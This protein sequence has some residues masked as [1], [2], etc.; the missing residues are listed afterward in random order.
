MNKQDG[1]PLERKR[2]IQEGKQMKRRFDRI[3]C[4]ALLCTMT[5]SLTACGN[6]IPDLTEDQSQQIGEYAAV[7]LL[8]YDAN[9]RSRLVE[10]DVVIARM[11]KE[12]QKAEA[13]E[14]EQTQEPSA[15][16][17]EMT[18]PAAQEDITTSL[19][20][21]FGLA[22]GLNLSYENAQIL[23]SYPEDGAA[24][25]YFAL[26]ASEG[27]KLLV[28]QFRLENTTAEAADVDLLGTASRYVITVNNTYR[29][30]ALTTMLPNDL[31]AYAGTIGAGEGEE[32]VLLAEIDADMADAVESIS[33]HLKNVSNEYTIQLQ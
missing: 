23:D 26:D 27:K 9:N 4:S 2:N 24:N 33:L 32:L 11:N 21:F 1:Y 19:E 17:T 6:Q 7:T 10:P 13:K 18:T 15:S 29:R 8:K 12:A 14:P 16:A 20:D 31:S 28:L 5:L 30:N 25:A 3:A 22:E